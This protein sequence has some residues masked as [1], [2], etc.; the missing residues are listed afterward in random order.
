M[1]KKCIILLSFSVY[2]DASP[3]ISERFNVHASHHIAHSGSIQESLK[4]GLI[5]HTD[6][7]EWDKFGNTPLHYAVFYNN[8]N[9]ITA[10]IKN[11]ADIDARNQFGQTPTFIAMRAQHMDVVLY[12][13]SKG[14]NMFTQD[15]KGVSARSMAD[16]N[17]LESMDV[18]DLFAQMPRHGS[19]T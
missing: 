11:H 14:A 18:V 9:N 1:I 6:L 13:I 12:L 19:P 16:A 2:F 4:S 15:H 7:N 3:I 8:K 5:I 10:L 17:Q